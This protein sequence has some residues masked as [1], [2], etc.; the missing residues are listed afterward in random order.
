MQLME[1]VAADIGQ[2]D[3]LHVV[4]HAFVRIEVGRV[5]GQLLQME[6]LG[7]STAQKVLDGLP[8]MDGGTIPDEDDP[9]PHLAQQHPQKAHYRHAVIAPLA[10]LQEQAPVRA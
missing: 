1:V 6:A 4:P 5:G 9:A 10:H 3:A 2:L 8:A 7:C